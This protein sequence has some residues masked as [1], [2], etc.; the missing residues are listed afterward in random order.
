MTSVTTFCENYYLKVLLCVKNK[1]LIMIRTVL[2]AL[3]IN[4]T[5]SN[6]YTRLSDRKESNND[7]K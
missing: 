6:I 3:I 4:T 5:D 1:F 7:D 2:L